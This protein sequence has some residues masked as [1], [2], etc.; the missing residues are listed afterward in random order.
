MI[1]IFSFLTFTFVA[2]A[3]YNIEYNSRTDAVVSIVLA[4]FFM[5]ATLIS[6]QNYTEKRLAMDERRQSYKKVIRYETVGDGHETIAVDSV[7]LKK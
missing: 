6:T 5:S 2:M 7:V 3:V 4:A 1:L